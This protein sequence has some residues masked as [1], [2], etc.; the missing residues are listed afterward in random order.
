MEEVVVLEDMPIW[1]RD[2]EDEDLAFIKN[3]LLASGSLKEVAL[4]YGVTYPT[5]R[6]RLDRLI[7]KIK[8]NEDNVDTPYIAMVK[9][10][11][12]DNKISYEVAKQLIQM[13]RKENDL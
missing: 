9:R 11:V 6:L 7:N 10:M 2:L 8:V 13:Y 5:V 3:L 4:H 12:I 1:M